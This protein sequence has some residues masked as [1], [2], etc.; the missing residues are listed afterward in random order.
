MASIPGRLVT[1][2]L[3]AGTLNELKL[4]TQRSGAAGALVERTG[5]SAASVAHACLLPPSCPLANTQSYPH[6]QQ[7]RADVRW[8]SPF[9][10]PSPS[11]WS[12]ARGIRFQH[13]AQG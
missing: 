3:L 10:L 12:R 11:G 13:P 2:L 8:Q 5:H 1:L 7:L 6:L 9:C 4:L